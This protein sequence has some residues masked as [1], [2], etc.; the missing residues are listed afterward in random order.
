MLNIFNQNNKFLEILSPLIDYEKQA[1]L[2]RFSCIGRYEPYYDD[3][4]GSMKVRH[5][6]IGKLF[7]N[8]LSSLNFSE[9]YSFNIKLPINNNLPSVSVKPNKQEKILLT[10][11][12]ESTNIATFY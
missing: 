3:N 8:Y 4:Y 6:E 10:Q 11:K 7:E 1:K 12:N 9:K 2:F 5:I